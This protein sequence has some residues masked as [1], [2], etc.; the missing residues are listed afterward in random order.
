MITELFEKEMKDLMQK[1][2][3][4]SALLIAST[5]NEVEIGRMGERD[6]FI[7]MVY[8]SMLSAM[9]EQARKNSN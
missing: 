3:I 7:D 2:N 6:L 1:H 8:R 9:I 5:E 4:A